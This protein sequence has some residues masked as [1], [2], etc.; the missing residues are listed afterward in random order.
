MT[1]RHVFHALTGYLQDYIH[2][3]VHH[4]HVWETIIFLT[5]EFLHVH[6][7]VCLRPHY[8]QDHIFHILNWKSVVNVQISI[9]VCIILCLCVCTNLSSGPIQ[10][11]CMYIN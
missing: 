9:S 6:V 7:V 3:I 2:H 5:D 10:C 8:L 4:S 1:R 11:L